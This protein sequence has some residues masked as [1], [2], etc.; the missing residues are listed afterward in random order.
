MKN[1]ELL[2]KITNSWFKIYI[3]YDVRG[4]RGVSGVLYDSNSVG[5]NIVKEELLDVSASCDAIGDNGDI[6]SG[7]YLVESVFVIDSELSF[8]DKLL[9]STLILSSSCS[10]FSSLILSFSS[11]L[12]VSSLFCSCWPGWV[13]WVFLVSCL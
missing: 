10:N 3:Y 11:Y 5:D 1:Q 4:V 12:A 2:K 8:F 13:L 6:L 9:I 7:I